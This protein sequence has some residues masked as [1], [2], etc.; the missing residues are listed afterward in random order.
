MEELT[1]YRKWIYAIVI[2]LGL[3]ISAGIYRAMFWTFVDNYEF[4]YK[5]DG[6][7]GE[8]Y[9]LTN[10][11]GTPQQGYIFAWPIVQSIHT[12]DTRPMQVCINANSRVLNCKLV[13]FDPKGFSTFVAWHGRGD[14]DKMNLEQILMSYAYDPANN[15]YPFLKIMKEL[16]NQEVDTTNTQENETTQI[17]DS[18]FVQPK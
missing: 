6:R 15:E 13:K 17:S 4:A 5:F 3:L 9:P 16:K 11:D 7:T 12:I 2:F 18:V 10:T 1:P 8:L 14:Y